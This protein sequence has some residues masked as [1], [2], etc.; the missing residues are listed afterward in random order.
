MSKN[1]IDL[2][3]N[4]KSYSLSSTSVS[5]KPMRLQSWYQCKVCLLVC[6]SGYKAQQPQDL[7]TTRFT[8]RLRLRGIT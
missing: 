8:R 7:Y 3:K 5:P 1:S 6:H 2:Q 4:L